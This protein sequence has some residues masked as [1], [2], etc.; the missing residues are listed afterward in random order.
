MTTDYKIL[1]SGIDGIVVYPAVP[2]ENLNIDY[3]KYVSKFGRESGLENTKKTF[4]K[5]PDSLNNIAYKK[6]AYLCDY[7]T[8][9]NLDL[10][11]KVGKKQLIIPFIDGKSIMEYI[12]NGLSSC[13]WY[14]L[15][16]ASIKFY[17]IIILLQNEKVY[18]NDISLDNMMYNEKTNKLLLID[19]DKSTFNEP[20][21]TSKMIGFND[22]TKQYTTIY[23]YNGNYAYMNDVKTYIYGIVFGIIDTMMEDKKYYNIMKKYNIDHF[24]KY[25]DIIEQFQHIK[26]IMP[27]LKKELCS[28]KRSTTSKRSTSYKT[29]RQSSSKRSTSSK[30]S[31]SSS[32]KTARQSSTKKTT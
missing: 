18:H 19:F 4:D 7:D 11:R 6:D 5:L 26:S 12:E 31:R 10:P 25:G 3:T 1:G 21:K 28:S 2:C 8:T 14:K 29:A 20:K 24:D 16:A 9:I 30:R 17:D 23:D 22:R 13:Q 27:Q 32:Y 15:L